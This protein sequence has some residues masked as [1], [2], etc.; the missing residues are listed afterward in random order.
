LPGET[1]PQFSFYRENEFRPRLANAEHTAS[2]R[3]IQDLTSAVAQHALAL[4]AV[5]GPQFSQ[6]LEHINMSAAGFTDKTAATS[7]WRESL[8]QD[9]FQCLWQG[10][11][12]GRIMTSLDAKAY[13]TS[14]NKVATTYLTN[15]DHQDV[16][17]RAGDRDDQGSMQWYKTQPYAIALMLSPGTP[18]IPNG[19]E[20]AADGWIPENDQGSSRRVV[21]RPLHWGYLGDKIG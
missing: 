4:D 10:N 6:T 2:T 11:L 13:L 9:C 14:P 3:G 19:Q 18:L 16:A 7:Y 5:N 20:F 21:G 8:Y 15:H 1:G 12:S 17:R